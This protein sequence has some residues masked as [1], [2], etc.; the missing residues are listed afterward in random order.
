MPVLLVANGPAS[1]AFISNPKDFAP[2]AG[3]LSGTDGFKAAYQGFA[4]EDGKQSY[5]VALWDSMDH[6]TK[7]I[8]DPKFAPIVAKMGEAFSGEAARHAIDVSA[9]TTAALTAPVTAILI[10]TLKAGQSADSLLTHVGELAK[11][12]DGGVAGAKSPSLYG[13][14]ATDANKVLLI[15]GWESAEAHQAIVKGGSQSAVFGKIQE[16]ADFTVAHTTLRKGEA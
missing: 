14:S 6:A 9:D 8:Q 1:D 15:T 3:L 12:L 10:F 11:N 16:A 4:I 7:A 5:T 13:K 2:P